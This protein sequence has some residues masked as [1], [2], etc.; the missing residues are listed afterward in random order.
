MEQVNRFVI[1]TDRESAAGGILA[2]APEIT[3]E[4]RGA[5]PTTSAESLSGAHVL[6]PIS[7]S[8]VVTSVSVLAYRLVEH[9]LRRMEH[10]V[11][12]DA[13]M[14][15]AV[16]SSLAGVPNGF[17]VVIEADGTTKSFSASTMGTGSLADILSKVCQ[18][19]S[20]QR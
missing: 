8:I 20:V 9:W 13:R 16:I 7:L 5:T 19:S 14:T 18:A 17:V 4:G 2:D 12:I 15:P 1:E 3:I 10:G 6:E 11:Q